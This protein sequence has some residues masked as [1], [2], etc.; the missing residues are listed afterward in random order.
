MERSTNEIPDLGVKSE[1][2]DKTTRTI[3]LLGS[4][5]KVARRIAPLLS[6]DGYRI[7]LAY[8]SGPSLA[9][10]PNAKGV[11]FDWMDTDTYDNPF[12]SS[13]GDAE[14]EGCA[15][16]A[17]FMI[18]PPVLEAFSV[19]KRFIDRAIGKGVRRIVFL[20]G[21]IQHCGDGPVLSRISEYIKR[22]GGNLG[23]PP[24]SSDS[25][26][27][28]NFS[29]MQH[30]YTIRD[31][32][33]ILSATGRGKIPFVSAED[34]A[35]VAYKAL[36]GERIDGFERG[37][38]GME[39]F[40]RGDQLWSYDDVASILTER[41][42]REIKHVDMGEE[43]IVRG[44]VEGGVEED[45]AKVLVEL[46]IAVERGE[47]AKLGGDLELIIGRRGRGLREYVDECARSGVWE[48]GGVKIGE[49]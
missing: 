35:L 42:G 22:K 14:V 28:A 9:S 16:D 2:K 34:V 30:L 12:V 19:A 15:I 5:G 24:E 49:C 44:M 29:E 21:S 40:L 3:L 47:E 43:D 7:L 45:L 13:H 10:L 37:L 20:S 38:A 32:N 4:T 1:N 39:L 23:S 11:R 46:E 26:F 41:L 25:H 8:R 18:S 36:I 48:K 33:Q 27:N 31:E 6:A 17:V